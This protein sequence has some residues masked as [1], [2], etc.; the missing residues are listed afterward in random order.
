MRTIDVFVD[1]SNVTDVAAAI[2][3]LE[4]PDALGAVCERFVCAAPPW[5][6]S[7]AR[8]GQRDWRVLDSE[9]VEACARAITAAADARRPLLVLAGGVE[10]GCEA[11]GVLL[12]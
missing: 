1:F 9:P 6:S 4:Q 7:A 3:R 8:D 10:P 5:Q 12:A 2:A 11:V